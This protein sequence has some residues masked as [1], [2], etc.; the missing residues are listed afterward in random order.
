LLQFSRERLLN[1]LFRGVIGHAGR[2][3]ACFHLGSS[4]CSVDSLGW[5]KWYLNRG[6]C[7]CL[8]VPDSPFAGA[9]PTRSMWSLCA[10][11]VR[12]QLAWR[13]CG[14]ESHCRSVFKL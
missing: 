14:E 6:C 8:S 5:I 4:L 10:V 12:L 11:C 13:S 9:T 2:V 3:L 1:T 7:Q